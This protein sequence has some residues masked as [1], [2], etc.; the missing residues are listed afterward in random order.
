MN[1][2]TFLILGILF[3]AS[4][5]KEETVELESGP[6]PVT[7]GDFRNG[8]VVFYIDS[9]DNTHGLVCAISNQSTGIQWYN[10]IDTTTGAQGIAIGTGTANTTAIINSQGAT[11]TDYAAGLA[12]AYTGGGYNDWFL[13]SQEELQELYKYKSIIDSSSIANG[14]S[15]FVN[16]ELYWSSTE[17]D[18]DDTQA[19][20]QYFDPN[21]T[22]GTGFSSKDNTYYIRAIRAF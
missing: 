7:I 21:G 22:G 19:I 14:G 13:P 8:G 18:Q 12:K 2:V 6:T 20:W 11:A 17:Y 16:N 10:G 15:G 1:K 9:N 5:K 4:C 3:I